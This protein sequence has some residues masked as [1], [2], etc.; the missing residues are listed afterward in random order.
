MVLK[1]WKLKNKKGDIR[2]IALLKLHKEEYQIELRATNVG[3]K[4]PNVTK[5]YYDNQSNAY[6]N[7]GVQVGTLAKNGFDINA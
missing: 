4:K 3:D 2:S 6:F 7:Y 1:H 5:F